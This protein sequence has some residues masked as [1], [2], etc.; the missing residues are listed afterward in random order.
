MQTNTTL[1][2][3]QADVLNAVGEFI[4][5]CGYSPAYCD[6]ARATGLSESRVRQHV[7]RLEALGLI[8]REPGTARSI[9]ITTR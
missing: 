2:P 5:A 7:D 3:R 9:R 8:A 6:L 4:D 1:T